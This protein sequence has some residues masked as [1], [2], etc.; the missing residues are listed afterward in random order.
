MLYLTIFN[1]LVFLRYLRIKQLYIPLLIGLF[2]F[3]AF[4]FEVG[5]DWTGYL[6]QFEFY[7]F[8]TFDDAFGNRE[9]LWLILFAAQHALGLS[10]PWINV[11][12]SLVFFG[13]VHVLARRQPDPVAFIILLFPILI[14]N[15][16]MSGI[17]Q[18]AAIGVVCIAFSEFNN[19]S[20]LK[21]VLYI[22][23]ASMLHSSAIILLLLSPFVTGAYYWR[24][25]ALAALLAIPGLFAI[26]A[27][28][29]A[30]LARSRYI[31]TSVD[32]AGAL[33]RVGLLTITAAFFFLI[34]R[35]KWA[36]AFPQDYNLVRAGSLIM[37]GLIFL[38]P[39]SSVIGDRLGYYFI[40]IQTII[41]SRLPFF[42]ERRLNPL[43]I[44]APY[45]AL[46]TTLAVW[47]TMSPL[48]AKC[49]T[50]YNSW[51]IGFPLISKYY[52]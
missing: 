40:P 9:S 2:V 26:A 42:P 5:C 41:L 30:E 45:I 29:D 24:R 18:G 32:A 6:N 16:P 52:Y 36:S 27:G 20:T 48:F 23:I 7:R 38:V 12:S 19:R 17:R 46:T 8:S 10:Y 31:G 15:M 1:S 14:L 44:A 33:F 13:G 49:Y 3:A 34:V 43:Y 35:R 21:F 4:R 47:V 50:P 37:A 28:D 51:I 22:I 11:F 25:F 39:I